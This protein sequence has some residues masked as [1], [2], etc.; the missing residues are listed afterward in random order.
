MTEELQGQALSLGTWHLLKGGVLKVLKTTGSWQISPSTCVLCLLSAT[1][2]LGY[3]WDS[4]SKRWQNQSL[5]STITLQTS[6]LFC[7]CCVQSHLIKTC[8]LSQIDYH[9]FS[10]NNMNTSSR[11]KYMRND[12]KREN[13]LIFYYIV[14]SLSLFY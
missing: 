1:Q 3:S 5:T 10:P 12:D 6:K 8:V 2:L 13:L 14:N 11:E 7:Q 4:K 9:Y